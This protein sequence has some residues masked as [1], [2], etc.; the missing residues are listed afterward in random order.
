M[1]DDLIALDLRVDR[2]EIL[3]REA[4]GLGERSS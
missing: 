2:R 1:I 3:E 4:G